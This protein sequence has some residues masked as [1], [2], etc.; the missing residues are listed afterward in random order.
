MGENSRKPRRKS[1]CYFRKSINAASGCQRRSLSAASLK[2]IGKHCSRLRFVD[3]RDLVKLNDHALA[4]LA[5]GCTSLR[6]LLFRRNSF[7]HVVNTLT[8]MPID[9]NRELIQSFR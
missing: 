8:F 4:H 3:F 6:R 1:S 2:E 7:R 9:V 5:G